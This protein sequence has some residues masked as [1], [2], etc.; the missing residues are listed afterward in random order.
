LTEPSAIV[1]ISRYA[2]SRRK[3]IF[4]ITRKIDAAA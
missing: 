3:N 4:A 1:H 2:A